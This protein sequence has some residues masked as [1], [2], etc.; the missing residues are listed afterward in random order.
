MYNA[1]LINELSRM[2]RMPAK[3]LANIENGKQKVFHQHEG[4]I[5]LPISSLNGKA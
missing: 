5:P 4:D 2:Y 1:L 3:K